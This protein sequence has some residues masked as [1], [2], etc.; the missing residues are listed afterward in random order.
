MKTRHRSKNPLSF[1]RAFLYSLH[2]LSEYSFM[3]KRHTAT[4][5]HKW[6]RYI[7]TFIYWL[8][9]WIFYDLFFG[10][11]KLY[12]VYSLSFS[13]IIVLITAG[14]VYF[15]IHFL[16]PKYLF[17]RRYGRFILFAI[18]TLIMALWL[19]VVTVVI[20]FVW[21]QKRSLLSQLPAREP[22]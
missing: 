14:S 11:G 10:Y 7:L 1:Y 22:L 8:L 19:E 18:Y 15:L 21:V 2:L 12:N 9:V 16:L 17:T 4:N 13:L 3:V 20:F 5:H 6:M